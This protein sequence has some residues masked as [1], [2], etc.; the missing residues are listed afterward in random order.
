VE[1]ERMQLLTRLALAQEDERRRIARELHDQLGQQLTA[2]R[3]TLELLK[4]RIGEGTELRV[5]IE[6]LEQLALQLDEDVGFRVWEL[7]PIALDELGLPEAVT[8]Y[9]QRWSQHT[10]I[11]VRLHTTRSTD[12]PLTSDVKITVYRLAQ[13][14]L[15]NVAKH[16]RADHVDVVLERRSEHV[17][18]IIEDNGV[19]FDASNAETTGKGLGLV[20]MRE[21]AALV[22]AQLQIESRPGGGTTVIVRAPVVTPAAKTT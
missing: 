12:E 17:S 10:G 19:G 2:L 20:G 15:N 22:G 14:A 9:A 6:T 4:S 13:E 3:I 7:R 11:P 8:S 16:A 5:Q 21:R 18:L 1:Q